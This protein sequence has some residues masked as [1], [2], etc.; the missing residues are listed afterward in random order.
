MIRKGNCATY[1][2]FSKRAFLT[3][4]A[5]TNEM[6]DAVKAREVVVL[7]R[8]GVGRLGSVRHDWWKV[9]EWRAWRPRG[10]S[11]FAPNPTTSIS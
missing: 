1:C 7:K 11:H 3:N 10:G 4:R 9:I 5:N 6:H 8:Q 2:L